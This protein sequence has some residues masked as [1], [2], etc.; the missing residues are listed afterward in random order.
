MADDRPLADRLIGRLKDN[1]V[2]A[3][4]IV[5]AFV[6]TTTPRTPDRRVVHPV[7]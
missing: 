6:V 1:P 2:V 3:T 5:P 7:R 4:L